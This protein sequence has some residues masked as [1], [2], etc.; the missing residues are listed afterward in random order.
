MSHKNLNIST[1]GRND[2]PILELADLSGMEFVA[3]FLTTTTVE[4]TLMMGVH[5]LR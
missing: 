4:P 3:P 2:S 1:K 5:M